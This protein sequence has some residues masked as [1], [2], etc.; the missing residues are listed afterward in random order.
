MFLQDEN[1]RKVQEAWLC[2]PQSMIKM[3]WDILSS[4]ALVCAC[5][6]TPF[7]LAFPWLDPNENGQIFVFESTW[8]SIE[9]VIDLVF[10]VELIVGFNT[11]FYEM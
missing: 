2:Y 11:S 8:T 10:M 3:T 4:V 7:G 9:S 1:K 6:M 5:F